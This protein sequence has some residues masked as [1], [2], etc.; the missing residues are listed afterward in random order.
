MP[1]DFF[2]TTKSSSFCFN[3][4]SKECAPLYNG[5]GDGNLHVNTGL[6]P[7]TNLNHLLPNE[8]TH[9]QMSASPSSSA[10]LPLSS[11]TNFK[12]Q[13][14]IHTHTF[15]NR[16]N[17]QSNYPVH[18]RALTSIATCSRTAIIRTNQKI[19]TILSV[20]LHTSKDCKMDPTVV[21]GGLHR[22]Q[23]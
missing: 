13:S 18:N 9:T 21:S 4:L 5:V 1:C 3:L 17:Q 14:C 11:D 8:Q 19:L 23:Y 6:V 20:E 15:C 22:K 2:F 7:R 10:L 16:C 12:V